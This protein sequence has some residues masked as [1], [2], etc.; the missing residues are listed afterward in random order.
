MTASCSTQRWNKTS[1]EDVDLDIRESIPLNTIKKE[2][3]VMK[4]FRTWLQEWRVR[5]TDDTLKVLKEIEEFTKDDLNYVLKFFFAE[6]RK[7]N[8]AWY[9]PETL[10][11]IAAMIQ[12]YFR[13][14][15]DW[16][17][18]F[19]YDKEFQTARNSLDAQM[20]KSARLGNAKPKRRPEA[21]TYDDENALWIN[22]TFGFSNPN[23]IINTLVY[24]FGI[25]FSLRAGQE[26]RD[27]EF[28]EESQITLCE[29]N[30]R[31]FLQYVERIS[32]NKRF[33]LKCTRMEP[34]C[35]RLYDAPDENRCIVKVY[36]EYLRHRPENCK[37]FYLTPLPT[38]QMKTE[39][40]FKKSPM[41]IHTLEKVTKN[42]MKSLSP[43]KFFTNTS[44]R[45]TAQSRLMK[46]GVPTEVIENKTGRISKSAT[47]AYVHQEW[48]EEEMSSVLFNS[49]V[50]MKDDDASTNETTSK[51]DKKN[52]FC[53]SNCSFDNCTFN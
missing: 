12:H 11:T 29:E 21:I 49:S 9:P 46:A 26:H 37:D 33:G 39:V 30:D 35:T 15:L 25:H 1:E 18:S 6:V 45:R 51:N 36:K 31:E 52:Q 10:K 23:Q 22:G 8:G 44:L 40:W 32:K 24:H 2:R 17:F 38:S 19:F 4:I 41:G 34:K 13:R 5:I 7:E 53:F 47:K 50:Q 27:L 3:W 48:F 16:K 20:K 42:I 28:G 14:E 43:Q